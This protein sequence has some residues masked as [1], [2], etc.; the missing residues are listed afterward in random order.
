[1]PVSNLAVFNDFFYR[2]MTETL[3][4]EVEL[5]NQQSGGALVL[6]S[7]KNVGSFFT[8]AFY[9]KISGGTVR[10]R[11]PF[12]QTAITS[13]SVSHKK[14]ISVK[15]DRGN[16]P[17]E[18]NATDFN[19]IQLQPEE[20]GTAYGAQYAQDVLEDMLLTALGCV[21][22]ALAQQPLVV[23]N[24]VANAAAADKLLTYA[25]MNKG[26][27]KFGDKS[28]RIRTWITNS[29]PRHDLIGANTTNA[30]QLHTI[31][32]VVLDRD[33][34]GRPLIVTDNSALITTGTPNVYHNLGLT[35]GSVIIE[36]NGDFNSATQEITGQENILYRMQNEYTYNVK[37][38]GF[39]WDITNGGESPA[40]AAMFT[41][42]NWDQIAT[43][44]KDL[45]GVIV[46]TN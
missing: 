35:P 17:L 11:N 46:E 13:K 34:Q 39:S 23:Y 10:Q 18:W 43:S 31:G 2:S 32:N 42:T 5:F 27:A 3:Q 8:E 37:V 29:G 36:Q 4:D 41:S 16:F 38:K 6:T 12:T 14:W 33:V 15:V 40:R 44:H 22:A 1:M 26:V 21:Y 20:A 19:R 45:P 7:A 24:A 25:N 9:A 28:N 30:A